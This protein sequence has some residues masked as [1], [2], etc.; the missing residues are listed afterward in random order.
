MAASEI[1]LRRLGSP[2]LVPTLPTEVRETLS[3]QLP[4]TRQRGRPQ[5][6]HTRSPIQSDTAW[7]RPVTSGHTVG[8]EDY[9]PSCFSN[10]WCA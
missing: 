2:S 1:F 10:Q 5:R 7:Y 9:G 4:L 8:Q 3:N 6:D